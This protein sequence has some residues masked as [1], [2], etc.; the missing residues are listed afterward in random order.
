[1][2]FFDSILK[3]FGGKPEK[4][5]TNQQAMRKIPRRKNQQ[6]YAGRPTGV[7]DWAKDLNITSLVNAIQDHVVCKYGPNFG[8]K[9]IMTTIIGANGNLVPEYEGVA[10]DCGAV[11]N[12]G[13]KVALQ[14]G[15]TMPYRY[16]SAKHAYSTCCDNPK[17]CPFYQAAENDA[18]MMAAKM[19]KR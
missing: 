17:R 18:A 16:I 4:N 2:S 8:M 10:G 12:F 6:V 3:M 13:M 1:M 11:H 14:D 19:K 5:K 9:K 15:M 7:P